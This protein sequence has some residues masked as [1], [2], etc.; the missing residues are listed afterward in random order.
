MIRLTFMDS[1]IYGLI[2]NNTSEDT[3]NI[4]SLINSG[5]PVLLVDDLEE[6]VEFGIINKESDI[7]MVEG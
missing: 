6:A 2:V 1:G 5:T 3:E 4:N 7:I